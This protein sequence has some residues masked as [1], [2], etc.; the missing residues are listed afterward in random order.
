MTAVAVRQSSPIN[1]F[2]QADIDAVL[3]QIR[4]LESVPDVREARARVEAMKAWAKAHQQIKAVRLDLLRMEVA[5]LVR[6]VELGGVDSL[7]SSERK[8]ARWLAEMTPADR[9]KLLTESGTATTATGM[10]RAVWN[11]EELAKHR[12]ERFTQGMAFATAPSAPSDERVIEDRKR[13]VIGVAAALGRIVD[14]HT[15]EGS[16][17]TVEQVAEELIGEAGLSAFDA[18][19]ALRGGIRSV[20]R[21]AIQKAPVESLDGTVLPRTIT[22]RDED[23]IFVRIPTPTATIA[24]LD[25]CIAMRQEQLAQDAAAIER[26]AAA[27]ERLME[28]PGAT[29]TSRIGALVAKSITDA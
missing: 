14:E 6:V 12:R 29:T 5:A 19:D 18:D 26:L 16:P 25:E 13:H 22:V 24:H 23:G 3:A 20:V 17:F 15:A 7:P 8:A 10:C 9:D 2:M 4:R 1:E 21:D 27:R 28:I 11:A